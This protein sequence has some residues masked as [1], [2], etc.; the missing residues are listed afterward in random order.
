MLHLYEYYDPPLWLLIDVLIGIYNGNV[1]VKDLIKFF[2]T[3]YDLATLMF[4][5]H[6]FHALMASFIKVDLAKLVVPDSIKCPFEV[7]LVVALFST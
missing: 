6:L 5:G 2:A 1:F 7:A 3:L 4:A